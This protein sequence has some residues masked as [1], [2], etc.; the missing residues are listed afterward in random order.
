MPTTTGRYA[1][2]PV[3]SPRAK[4]AHRRFWLQHTLA[5]LRPARLDKCDTGAG[6]VLGREWGRWTLRPVS[7]WRSLRWITPPTHATRGIPGTDRDAACDWSM[8]VLGV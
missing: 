7:G 1:E 3:S 6:Y 8:D 2:R 5:W 4:L